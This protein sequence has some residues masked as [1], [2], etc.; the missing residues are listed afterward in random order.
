MTLAAAFAAAR[1]DGRAAFI[2][3]VM[4]GDP[5]L[6]T[7]AL[8]LG[9]LR[10]AGA[11]AVELGIPYSDALADGPTI[12][13]A[14]TRALKDGVGIDDVLNVAR[15]AEGLPVVLFS[16][17]NPILQYGIDRFARAAAGAGVAAVIVPDIPLEESASLGA[18]LHERGLDMPLLVAPS[19][20]RE[21]ARRIAD[22]STGF[23]Y[24]VSRTGVTGAGRVPDF[25][26]ANARLDDLRELT[27]KPLAAGFGVSRPEHVAQIAPFADGV[28]VGSALIDA[29]WG[30]SGAEAAQR[31]FDLATRL[32]EATTRQTPPAER[33]HELSV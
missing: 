19:T 5:D 26:A 8:I 23:V 11:D 12:V 22:R 3:Y 9:A 6:E 29:Y 17:F 32:R 18:V 28:I 2:P 25:A 16:Y 30:T 14:A 33:A 10:A 31:V 13:A 7:T 1:A 24:V 21:R 20:G 15:R 27:D 4:A